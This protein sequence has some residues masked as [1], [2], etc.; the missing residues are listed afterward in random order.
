M[1]EG[2]KPR[3]GRR[4]G[5]VTVILVVLLVAVY[6]VATSAFFLKSVIL[7]KVGKSMNA[8]ITVSDASIAPFSQVVLHELKVTTTS[9]LVEAREVRLRYKLMDIIKG[10]INV[11]EVTLD[12]PT[13]TIVK[14]VDGKSNLDPI[15]NQPKKPEDTSKKSNTEVDVKNLA[16]KNA[17]VRITQKTKTGQDVTELSG[18]NVTLDQLKNGASGKL[19]IASAL[20]MDQAATNHLGAKISGAYDFSLTPALGPQSIKGSTRI[21]VNRAEGSLKDAA[22][23]IA[24][25]E[26]DASPTSVN[27]AAFRFEKSGQTLGQLRV[28][29]PFDM[30]KMEGSLTVELLSLDRNVLNLAGMDFGQSKINSTNKIDITRAAKMIAIDGKLSGTQLGV[31]RE[32]TPTPPVDLDLTYKVAADLDKKMAAVDR[33]LMSARHNNAEFLSAANDRPLNVSWGG[34]VSAVKDSAFRLTV[35]NFNLADWKTILGTNPPAGIVNAGIKLQAQE[36]GKKLALDL[37]TTVDQFDIGT[38][39]FKN[40]QLVLQARGTVDEMKRVQLPEFSFLMRSNNVQSVSL[41][42]NARYDLEKKDIG[43]QV[44]AELPAPA[45]AATN[46][47]TMDIALD[48]G[49]PGNLIDLRDLSLKLTPT[50]RAENRLQIQAKLDLGKTNQAPATISV[51]SAGLDLTKYYDLFAGNKSTAANQNKTTPAATPPAN[52][53]ASTNPN[54]EPAA[55]DL[56]IKQL[57]ANVAIDKLFLRDVAISNWATTAVISNNNVRLNPLKLGVNGAPVTGDVNLNL[58][59]AGYVYD[60]NLKLDRVPLEPFANS[61]ATTNAGQYKGFLVADAAIRGAGTTGANLQKS[62][63]GQANFS[64][65]NLDLQIVGPKIKKILVPISI[66]LRAPELLQTPINWVDARTKMGDGNIHV[67]KMGVQSAAF[68]ANVVGDIIIEKV[69]TNSPLNLP[70]DLQLRRSLAQKVSFLGGGK[71]PADAEYVSLPK[72]VTIKGTLGDPKSDINEAALLGVGLNAI[73]GLTKNAAVGN[74]GALLNSIT[75]AGGSNT[76]TAGTN[77]NGTSKL[78][79]GLGGLLGSN[80]ATNSPAS[81]NTSTTNAAPTNSPAQ[82]LLNIFRRNK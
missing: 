32:K 10:H 26:A 67:E 7:P 28:H 72:F 30:A 15:L 74:A 71:I 39:A 78:I 52:G 11:D 17:L 21:E 50:P 55:M 36:D 47:L 19:T 53:N 22:G 34:T 42:G 49:M 48:A 51:K 56:P 16:L 81:T 61:F 54:S 18:L 24:L 29:G 59:V 73:G 44:A 80:R 4:L 1:D 41:K 25:L 63:R 20:R 8:T 70:V 60:L 62:L 12:S 23:M 9:P 14:E 37:T 77:A 31:I 38:N 68:Y 3:W 76:N 5:I 6:F 2:R 79:Q 45:S 27:N 57:T 64:V 65:T 13:V 46:R 75:G 43:L 40:V 58:G 66:V 82:N 69:L 35:T 33:L